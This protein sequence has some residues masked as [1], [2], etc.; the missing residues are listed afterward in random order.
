MSSVSA[1]SYV[2]FIMFGVCIVA[3]LIAMVIYYLLSLKQKSNKMYLW[4]FMFYILLFIFFIYIHSVIKGLETASLKAEN[5][6]IMN[7]ICLIFLL[8][9][10][11]FALI[12]FSRTLGFNLKQFEFKK[13]LEEIQIDSTDNE[14]VELTLGAD[15][16]KIKRTFRKLLRL[17]RYFVLENRLFVI[18]GSS[19]IILVLL[20]GLY[21]K[22][23]VY[24]VSYK[25][26][27]SIVA[28]RL[29]Y[30]I[31]ES[32]VTNTNMQNKIINQG[33]YYVVVNVTISNRL[34]SDFELTREIFTL[35]TKERKVYPIFSVGEGFRDLG[36]LYS[37]GIMKASAENEYIVIFEIEE[38]ELMDDYILKIKNYDDNSFGIIETKYKNIII[39]PKNI[40][41]NVDKGLYEL[42][43][44]IKFE[45]TILKNY[46]VTINN[47]EMADR[48]R[49][50]YVKTV[51]GE[52]IDSV[53]VIEPSNNNGNLSILKIDATLDNID[54]E[55]Y[56]SRFI[57]KPVDLFDYYGLIR[58]R[59]MG[60]YKTVKLNKIGVKYETDKYSYLEMPNEVLLANKIEFLI[61]IRG[62]KYTFNLK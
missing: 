1:S 8:P 62:I 2:D 58:Y 24:S 12:M 49:E 59:Y 20:L 43:S 51:D 13:D 40:S 48:F 57:K 26:N 36:E 19:I 54:N 4:I 9:Q 34:A 15:T 37:P 33:K 7:E 28:N 60:N 45:D 50:K 11:F 38:N 31:N 16:Y 32:Y 55:V 35:V 44:T 14:E 29:T 23:N 52:K 41:E 10:I 22:Y 17:G 56:M 42:K 30:K 46:E 6:G 21:T 25:E 47:F 39:K 5:I 27:Q 61:V 53:Y 18:G 3:I